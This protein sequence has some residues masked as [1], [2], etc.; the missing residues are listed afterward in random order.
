MNG[1]VIA[2]A[3]GLPDIEIRPERGRL[4]RPE[5]IEAVEFGT[6]FTPNMFRMRWVDGAWRDACIEP[7]QELRLH[8]GATVLHYAQS[9]FE[10]LK[11]YRQKSG[12]VVLFRPEMNLAR[13][14]ATARR[15]QMPEIPEDFAMRAILALVEVEKDQIPDLPG[16]L[17]IRP[18][19]I[20]TAPQVKVAPSR[21]YVFYILT[22]VSGPY[23]RGTT[24]R[25]PGAVCVFIAQERSRAGFGGTGGVKAGANYA[26]TLEI[27]A[28]ARERKCGQVLFLEARDAPL[29]DR[30]VEE[31]GGMNVFFVR[32]GELHTPALHGTILPG[33]TR[34]SLLRIARAEGIRVHER[35]I[36]FGW[37]ED[38]LADG[39]I[40]EAFA[41]GTAAVV[42][43]IGAFHYEDGREMKPAAA[44]PGPMT[45]RLF[46]LLCGIQFGDLPDRFGWLRKACRA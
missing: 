12:D 46:S 38:G 4:V 44:A 3:E 25:D 8:P 15:M 2:K 39:G 27:T 9:A 26:G 22:L 32:D 23:F 36:P 13:M 31:M 45:N 21:E 6:L 14:N 43:G 41:C 28:H 24:G 7:V 35:D 1:T 19:L 11:A 10:G 30:R 5:R 29:R 42:T 40:T 17:Y 34:D 20:G 16:T 18:T 33:V 37:V